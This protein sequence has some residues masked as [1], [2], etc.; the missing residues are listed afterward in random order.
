MYKSLWV[1]DPPL[2]YEFKC[3]VI[4]GTLPHSTIFNDSLVCNN[5]HL[6]IKD[7]AFVAQVLDR[8]ASFVA[9]D[10]V[11]LGQAQRKLALAMGPFGRKWALHSLETTQ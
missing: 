5:Q 6:N 1:R 10:H 11:K 2:A 9:S 8:Q 7:I 4:E 3:I